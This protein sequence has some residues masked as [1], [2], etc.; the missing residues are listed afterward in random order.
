MNKVMLTLAAAALAIVLAVPGMAGAVGNTSDVKGGVMTITVTPKAAKGAKDVKLW[1]P[2]PYSSVNQTISDVNVEGNYDISGVYH[3]EKSEANYLYAEWSDVTEAPKLVLSFHVDSKFEK[4]AD[5]V[6]TDAP[7]PA[8]I[9]AKYLASS[10]VVPVEFFKEKAAKIVQGKRTILAKARAVYDW[11]VDNTFRDP[12][13]QGCGLAEPERTLSDC[14]GGGKCADISA[15]FVTILRAAGVPARDVY[16][17]RLGDPKTG[18]VT[19]AY[20]CWA[21][22]YLP[23]TGWVR[24]DPADV[25]KM[26]LVHKLE[27]GSA[28]AEAWREYFWGGDDLF[29]VVLN[30]NARNVTFNPAQQGDPVNYFMYPYAEVNGK[31]LDYF[32]P[33]TF[34]YSVGFEAD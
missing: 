14:K 4:T 13:V 3:D 28:Q 12:A 10:P 26:M 27:D 9:A 25:R 21:E 19:S 16:G 22:F 5:L 7:I 31:P 2:Y 24:A 17:L 8:P 6:D 11:T 18:D 20:H 32:N 33:K 30:K 23:G 15:V 34:S 1:L 29:R